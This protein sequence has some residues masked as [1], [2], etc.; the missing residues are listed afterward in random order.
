[1][2][3]NVTAEELINI[4]KSLEN[5]SSS[6]LNE[7]KA[8]YTTLDDLNSKWEGAGSSGYYNII[9]SYKD[10]VNSLGVVINQYAV[11]LN[12]AA[13]TYTQTDNDIASQASRL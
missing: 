11:F 6:F 5:T 8:M 13:I 10:D 7:V 2:N 1:M 9:N 3:F 12:K 4:S